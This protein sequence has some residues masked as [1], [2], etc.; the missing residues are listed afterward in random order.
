MYVELADINR[1]FNND[2][3][4]YSQW[5]ALDNVNKRRYIYKACDIINYQF[6]FLGHTIEPKQEDAF[7]RCFDGYIED[8]TNPYDPLVI[9]NNQIPKAVEKATI[10]LVKILVL[11]QNYSNLE[12][13]RDRFGIKRVKELTSEIEFSENNSQNLSPKNLADMVRYIL[14]DFLFENWGIVNQ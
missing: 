6:A 1:A 4:L 12:L 3:D 5:S 13:L 9:W 11:T 14:K 2:P 8:S 10:E 7:P